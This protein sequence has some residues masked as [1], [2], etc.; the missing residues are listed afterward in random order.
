MSSVGPGSGLMH[1]RVAKSF[2]D[3]KFTV[4]ADIEVHKLL[5][6]PTTLATTSS[7]TFPVR[8]AVSKTSSTPP[9]IPRTNLPD[10]LFKA[11]LDPGFGHYEVVGIL[12]PFRDR[13]YPCGVGSCHRCGSSGGMRG[14]RDFRSWRRINDGRIGGGVGATAR[15]P[16]VAKKAD[17]MLHF[18]GGDG[19]G[20][21]SSAQLADVTAR[22]D[23]TLAPIRGAAYL[24][25]L[26][27]HPSP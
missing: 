8:V 14:Q 6:R 10:F 19:I 23:G 25:E 21:Y 12:S 13:V 11:A 22:P 24:A 16:V 4:A 9:G 18:Q 5:T 20:R 3:G 7:S 15:L 1:F 17:V 2:D 27:L 26:E